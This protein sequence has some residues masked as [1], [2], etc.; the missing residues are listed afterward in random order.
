[1]SPK[2]Q[3]DLLRALQEREVRRLGGDRPVAVDVRFIAATNKDLVEA[4]KGGTFREDLY[5]RLAV[6]PI[7]LPALRERP[8]DIPLLA[9]VFLREFC[10]QY[11]RPEKSLSAAVLQI[12]REDAWPGNVRELRNLAERLAVTPPGPAH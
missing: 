6:V 12:F 11:E 9:S 5:Y 7:T 4:V 1:M 8:E 10:G 2:T 3:V